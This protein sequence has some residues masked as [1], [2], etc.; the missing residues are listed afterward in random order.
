MSNEEISRRITEIAQ[1]LD[2]VEQMAQWICDKLQRPPIEQVRPGAR[3][4]ASAVPEPLT[5]NPTWPWQPATVTQGF[6]ANRFERRDGTVYGPGATQ[7][8]AHINSPIEGGDDA[9]AKIDVPS[10]APRSG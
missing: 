8:D 3:T 5:P 1:H 10:G 9:Q 6:L 2:R 4:A 7:A